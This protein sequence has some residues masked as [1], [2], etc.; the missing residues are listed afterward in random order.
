MEVRV[1][2]LTNNHYVISQIDEVATEDIGQPDCKLTK[3]YIV[4]T[5]SG[6]TKLEPFMR[7]LTRDDTFM[8]GSDKIQAPNTEEVNVLTE[9][10]ELMLFLST[11]YK[12]Y[13]KRTN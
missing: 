2:A 5:E 7:D 1:L 4:D 8:M 12:K 11:M 3:P 9:L 10:N 6:E 13:S